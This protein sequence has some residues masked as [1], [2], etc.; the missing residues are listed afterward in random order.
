MMRVPKALPALNGPTLHRLA[1][2]TYQKSPAVVRKL[3]VTT[4]RHTDG[5][6]QAL[7]E[8]RVKTPYIEALRKQRQEGIDPTKKGDTPATPPDRD[9][10]PK[11][12]SESFHRVV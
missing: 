11:K 8:M 2:T 1:L 7:T 5:V 6:Y 9:L 3:H 12:M 4:P 10:T